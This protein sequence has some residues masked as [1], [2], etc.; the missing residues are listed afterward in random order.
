[1]RAAASYHVVMSVRAD[2]R[3]RFWS[4]TEAGSVC[5]GDAICSAISAGKCNDYRVGETSSLRLHRGS[6]SLRA[7]PL[8]RPAVRA[9]V[10]ASAGEMREVWEV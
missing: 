7:A 8:R 2:I 9:G 3:A 5:L 10:P 6:I 1:M 4:R